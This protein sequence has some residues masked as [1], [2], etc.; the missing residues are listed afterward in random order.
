M[1]VQ[2]AAPR[3]GHN[4]SLSEAFW[5]SASTRGLYKDLYLLASLRAHKF[6]SRNLLACIQ[7]GRR[8]TRPKK[9]QMSGRA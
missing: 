5:R 4:L 6:K 8:L 9:G 7:C 1:S 2:S 3:A